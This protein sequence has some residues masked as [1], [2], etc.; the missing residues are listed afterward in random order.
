MIDRG[1]SNTYFSIWELIEFMNL[2]AFEKQCK[3]LKAQ[4][5]R[6]ALDNYSKYPRDQKL[7]IDLWQSSA[8]SSAEVS[9]FMKALIGCLIPKKLAPFDNELAG[10]FERVVKSAS[11]R[12]NAVPA[13]TPT[14][15]I[16][17]GFDD[18][19]IDAANQLFT[20]VEGTTEYELA[21]AQM[22][23]MTK[24]DFMEFGNTYNKQ[25]NAK[26]ILAKGKKL[27]LFLKEPGVKTIVC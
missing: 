20:L 10:Q 15:F 27:C 11:A 18:L 1:D 12:Q 4:W 22:L 3:L 7:L 5:M 6:M 19:P 16:K 23:A 13:L 17:A 26:L 24:V 2:T 8:A 14:Q 25:K 9:A 21:S